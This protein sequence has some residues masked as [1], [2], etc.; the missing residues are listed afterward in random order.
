[1]WSGVF[2]HAQIR[3]TL[4]LLKGAGQV[5]WLVTPQWRL[6]TQFEVALADFWCLSSE[7]VSGPNS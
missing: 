7:R 1:M 5:N 6:T 4:P 3:Q 2:D